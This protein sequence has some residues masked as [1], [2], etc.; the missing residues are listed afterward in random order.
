MRRRR[1]AVGRKPKKR[2]SDDYHLDHRGVSGNDFDAQN[3]GRPGWPP[4]VHYCDIQA[5]IRNM[6]SWPRPF[7]LD[8]AFFFAASDYLAR[9]L[10]RNKSTKSKF[11]FFVVN[12]FF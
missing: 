1:F 11:D 10:N 4:V 2:W 3:D 6:P 12:C 9:F 8:A 7:L 5:Y